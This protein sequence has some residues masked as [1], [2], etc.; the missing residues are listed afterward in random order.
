VLPVPPVHKVPFEVVDDYLV[1]ESR[2]PLSGPVVPLPGELAIRGLLAVDCSDKDEVLSFVRDHGTIEDTAEESDLFMADDVAREDEANRP[3]RATEL[4]LHWMHV[5]AHLY[6]AQLLAAHVVAHLDGESVLP[7]WQSRFAGPLNFSDDSD[8]WLLFQQALNYGV[9]WYSLGVVAEVPPSGVDG[10]A[11]SRPPAVGLYGAL[12]LQILNILAEGLPTHECANE[13]CR[14]R[15][16]RQ[17]GRAK[18]GQYRKIG[19]HYCSDRCAKAQ[20]QRNYYKRQQEAK[21]ASAR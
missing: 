10:D 18:E 9:S 13:R 15:F 2:E 14:G 3:S 11:P 19:V 17:E 21:K 12:C 1:F 5:A 16:I 6:E 8:A 20:T 7:V 4:W